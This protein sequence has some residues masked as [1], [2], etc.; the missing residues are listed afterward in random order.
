MTGDSQINPRLCPGAR[1][2]IYRIKYDGYSMLAS[3]SEALQLKSKTH[4]TSSINAF[5]QIARHHA[6]WPRQ[7]WEMS[8]SEPDR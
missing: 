8:A 4:L 7:Y 6:F 1:G 3:T 5:C 2:G